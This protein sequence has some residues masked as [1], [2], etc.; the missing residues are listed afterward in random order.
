MRTDYGIGVVDIGGF[1][2]LATERGDEE[3]AR[4]LA[5]CH[6]VTSAIAG[7]RGVDLRW[8]ANRVVFASPNPTAVVEA[9]LEFDDHCQRVESPIR[10]RGGIGW[11]EMLVFM[12]GEYYGFDTDIHL[13]AP[14]ATA[15]GMAA[16]ARP[17]EILSPLGVEP[18]LPKWA[19]V[20]RV[21]S[22]RVRGSRDSVSSLRIVRRGAEHHGSLVGDPVCGLQ[23]PR[24]A[25]EHHLGDL[26][27]C[28]RNCREAWHQNAFP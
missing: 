6:T 15:R 20:E 28:S 10:V 18:Y 24:D 14:L 27:F 19:R 13:G 7:R 12:A 2:R 4:V 11:G 16:L 3:V 8:L 5:E 9:A 26:S 22:H 21:K 17:E 1:T 25:V 23:L